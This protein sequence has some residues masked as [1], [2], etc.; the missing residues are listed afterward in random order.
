M[1]NTLSNSHLTEREKLREHMLHM[2]KLSQVKPRI[3]NRAPPAPSHIKTKN[4]KKQQERERQETIQKDNNLLLQ[5]LM[6]ID[7]KPRTSMNSSLKRNDSYQKLEANRKLAHE[8]FGLLKRIKSAKSHYAHDKFIRDFEQQQY[9]KR[10]LSENARRV[11]RT[12]NFNLPLES[13]PPSRP[14]SS[15]MRSGSIRAS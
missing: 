6:K 12:T 13:A 15:Y 1:W 7:S 5:K 3:D 8:N 4:K 11:P 14:A 2:Y 10:K 9:L